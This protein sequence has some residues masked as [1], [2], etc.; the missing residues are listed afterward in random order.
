MLRNLAQ[1][2]NKLFTLL[3]LLVL[4][5]FVTACT[6]ADLPVVGKYFGDSSSDGGGSNEPADLTVW[7]L[8]E[9]PEV[10]NALISKY[11]EANPNVNIN[12]DDRSVLNPVDYKER[13]FTRASDAS[14]PDIMRVHVSWLP[15]LRNFLTPMPS[16]MIDLDSFVNDNYPVVVDSLVFN[17]ELYGVP[18]GY[19]GLVLVYNKA[20]FQEVGQVEPPTVWEE[21]RELALRLTVRGDGGIVRAGA[22]IGNADNIDFFSDIIGLLFSQA[23]VTLPDEV[24]TKPAQDALTFYTNFFREDRVW[25]ANLPEA[26]SAFAQEKVS[27]IFVPSWNLLDILASRPDLDIG[28]APPPQVLPDSPATWASFWVDVVPQSSS[29]ARPAWRYLSFLAQPEQQLL[30]YSE[31]SKVRG[32]GVPYSLVSLSSELSSNPYLKSVLDTAPYA[33]TFEF[34]SRAGNR[35]QVNTMQEVVNSILSGGSVQ[36][37]LVKIKTELS[38]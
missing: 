14:G 9:N 18:V 16:G 30:A 3:L 21:F 4:P 19:D 35:R 10:T 28:V 31:A 1:N 20:H 23:N 24:D 7:G 12:Y 26:S 22:A 34:A 6:L 11:Q 5:L 29:N 37:G 27:M 13:V 32:Y 17:N 33:K 38:K 36:D 15:R 25:A 8:W 2:K